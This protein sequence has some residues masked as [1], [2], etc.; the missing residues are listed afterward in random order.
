MWLG[1]SVPAEAETIVLRNGATIQVDGW[2]D[3][4]DAVEFAVGGGLV[5]VLKSDIEKIEGQ[6]AKGDLRMYSAPSGAAAPSGADRAALLKQMTEL[7]TQG[8]GLVTQTVLTAAEKAGAFRRLGEAWTA[9]QAP[10]E[11]AAMHAKGRQALE[12]AAEAFV[13]EG[14]G[15][16]PDVKERVDQARSELQAVQD[17]LKK[18]G[19]Q[20]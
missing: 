2:R 18:L 3:V 7:L 10:E 16:A 13:A 6:A 14:Q 20:G 17:E 8:E 11:L 15:T 19:P 12:L 9:I 1:L 5:R 4:G